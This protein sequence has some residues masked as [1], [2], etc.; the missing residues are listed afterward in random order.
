ME[1]RSGYKDGLD[2][3]VAAVQQERFPEGDLAACNR[4]AFIVARYEIDEGA[5]AL[6][7]GPLG[8]GGVAVL[9]GVD[10]EALPAVVDACVACTVSLV[11]TGSREG[12]D[13]AGGRVAEGSN[14]FQQLWERHDDLLGHTRVI[15]GFH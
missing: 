13:E 14:S 1:V 2:M 15:K 7:E 11:I 4:R 12:E 6:I 10:N 8:E 9:K 3:I 5:A